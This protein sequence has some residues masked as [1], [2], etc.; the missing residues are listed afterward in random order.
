M[1]LLFSFFVAFLSAGPI[2][3]KPKGDGKYVGL[4]LQSTHWRFAM[5]GVEK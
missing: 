4:F 2:V 1:L 5:K 3:Q